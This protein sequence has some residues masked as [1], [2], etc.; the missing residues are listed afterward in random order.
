MP[1]EEPDGEEVDLRTCPPVVAD[2]SG[3]GALDAV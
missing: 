1:G 3:D 2:V